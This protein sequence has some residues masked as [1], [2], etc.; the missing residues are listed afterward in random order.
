[1]LDFSTTCIPSIIA[2]AKIFLVTEQYYSNHPTVCIAGKN[3]SFRENAGDSTTSTSSLLI[4]STVRTFPNPWSFSSKTLPIN[5]ERKTYV[6]LGTVRFGTSKLS[7]NSSWKNLAN[8]SDTSLDPQTLHLLNTER[9]QVSYPL[10]SPLTWC[11]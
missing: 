2:R 8:P 11:D 4:C 7:V 6:M 5:H 3:L 9:N 10:F 1:M